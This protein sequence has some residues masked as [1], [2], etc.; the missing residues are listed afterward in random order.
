VASFGA[1]WE[2]CDPPDDRNIFI[3]K[4]ADK[5]DLLPKE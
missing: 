4:K 3:P 1:A 5:M 2:V